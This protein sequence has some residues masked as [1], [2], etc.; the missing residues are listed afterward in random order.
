MKAPDGLIVWMWCGEKAT[1]GA[2]GSARSL[3]SGPVQGRSA[4]TQENLIG[5][6][7]FKAWTAIK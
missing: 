7:A 2:W 3:H 5:R 6:S 4:H 1:Q